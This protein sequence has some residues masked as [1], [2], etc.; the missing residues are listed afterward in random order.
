ML[1]ITRIT[2]ENTE[3]GCVTDEA[4]PRISFSAVSDVKGAEIAD[5]VITVGSWSIH[6]RDQIAI[7]YQGEPLQPYT[8]YT[9]EISVTDT[10]GETAHRNARF[11]TGRMS[12]PWSGKWITDGTYKFTEK[13][14]SPQ[15]LAFRRI[16]ETAPGKEIASA[17]IYATA[18]GIY[19][20]ALD[21]KLL[22]ERYFA[23]GF[24]SYK[25]NLQYQTYDITNVIS[26]KHVLTALVAGGWA[27]GSF[28][29]TRVNRVSAKRQALLAEIRITY[30]DGSQDV[31]GTADD[32]QV[33]Q[34]GPVRMAD[35]Y[36]GE[37][38]D[39]RRANYWRQDST[40]DYH[41]HNAALEKLAINPQ[42]TAEYGA[43]VRAHEVFTPVECA[44]RDD[45]SIIYDM[46]QNFA[47]VV[48]L[49]IN[50][51]Y[52]GQ[53][54]TIKHAEILNRDGSLNTDFL[55]TAKATI[56]YT[57]T[58]GEQEYTPRFTYMGFRYISVEGIN[59]DSV[60]VEG[61]AL[62]SDMN[63]IGEFECSNS[64][65]NQLQSN[66]TWGAKS[67]LV[68]IPTDCPQRDE[69][70]GWTGDIAVFGPT[71]CF[72]FDMSRFLEKWLK[73]VQA[74]QTR[75]GG[76]PNTVPV[77]GYGF[78]ATMPKMAID[79]WG[80]ACVLVPWAL[81]QSQGDESI[82]RRMY[83]TMKKYVK[84]CQFWAKLF[85]AGYKR[86][87]WNTPSV[88]HFGDWVAPD[89]PQMSQWQARSP[90][91]ATASLNN[92]S[93]TLARIAGILGETIDEQY[94]NNLA[95]NV[96]DAYCRE[97]TDG[98]GKLTNE[99]QTA[100]VLPLYLNMFP[101]EARSQAVANLASLVEKG[102]YTIGTGFPGTPYILFALADNGRADVAY[103]MLLNRL[104]PGWLYEVAMG[105][106]TIWERWDGLDAN[107]ECP[108][109][110]DGTDTMISYNH[111]ASGA[112]G[113]FLYQ[114]VA[115]IEAT[116]P[117][118]K[119]FR[120]HP[121]IGGDVTSA[122]ARV[123]TAYGLIESAWQLNGNDVT[124]T[125][126]VP[127]GTTCTVEIPVVSDCDTHESNVHVVTSGT[128]TFTVHNALVITDKK[129]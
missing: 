115:G 17:R 60:D 46:G 85:S 80:D 70:M 92:T 56:T 16:I 58:E 41:W 93:R 45:G 14:V 27:V 117:A 4:H 78:P 64:D 104:C 7:R 19:D 66:I 34:D 62:Y 75:G 120:V 119:T 72:N 97:F 48:R 39:A 90:W 52:E 1:S 83:P 74:E 15:P 81:Y 100:Y 113:A 53:T 44:Q 54:I 77:Q 107:G 23:P 12:S 11:E 98:H 114:R 51:A 42:I 124:V 50:N 43:P 29:F 84:A 55:R 57:C 88:L 37:T 129:E 118:Y 63:H 13:K 101:E 21:G 2:V 108:I 128:H 73:D 8:T 127:M 10:A 121:L 94:Y 61:I 71:A 87:I 106:T 126:T 79:W 31:I 86:Y 67:N 30:T 111:Y 76:I 6:T 49:K 5:A 22:D 24:T 96:A 69:R 26:G 38:Y 59:G 99:F 33:S 123:D 82:L 102:Q 40:G 25:T 91:T 36:D 125:V 32:W 109:G 18:M 116:S 28:V 9:V 68:D 95:D 47:G 65:L 105:A 35:I 103:K 110:D 20:L 3:S 89:V 112:V 122:H